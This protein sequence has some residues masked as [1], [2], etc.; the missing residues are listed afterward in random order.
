MEITVIVDYGNSC[1]YSFQ[2]FF[3]RKQLATLY[4]LNHLTNTWVV[5]QTRERLLEENERL[6]RDFKIYQ[7]IDELQNG[8]TEIRDILRLRPDTAPAQESELCLTEMELSCQPGEITIDNALSRLSK[9]LRLFKKSATEL[10]IERAILTK[11][12]AKQHTLADKMEER[13]NISRMDAINCE[14][15]FNKKL[16][17]L[18]AKHQKEISLLEAKS[19]KLIYERH[20]ALNELVDSEIDLEEARIELQLL[21]KEKEIVEE[22]FDDLWTNKRKKKGLKKLLF[23]K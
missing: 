20:E 8:F 9:N 2:N 4:G 19:E 11:E 13:L 5:T 6:S 12:I 14:L 7:K 1:F 16:H 17:A 21:T 23:W 3:L 10:S 22:Q 18:E 15:V